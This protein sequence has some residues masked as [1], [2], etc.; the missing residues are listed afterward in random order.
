[1]AIQG[2]AV[3]KIDDAEW[4]LDLRREGAAHERLYRG[5]PKDEKVDITLTCSDANFAALV[6]GKLNPQQVQYSL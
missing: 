2:I 6:M 3:F 5:P 1:M 4:T